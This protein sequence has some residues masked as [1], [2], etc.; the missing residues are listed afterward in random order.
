MPKW[1]GRE[2]DGKNREEG[3]K[4]EIAFS[5]ARHRSGFVWV[6]RECPVSCHARATMS[7]VVVLVHIAAEDHTANSEPAL[8][9]AANVPFKEPYSWHRSTELLPLWWW[10]T[11]NIVKCGC[12]VRACKGFFSMFFFFFS[13]NSVAL[14]QP[15]KKS[16]LI[17]RHLWRKKDDPL[18]TQQHNNRHFFFNF[19]AL[20]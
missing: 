12:L 4:R 14:H 17:S 1:T 15:E 11:C 20:K 19:L 9:A 18:P 3:R 5:P 16:V 13:Q 8:L 2:T 6:Q 7:R 10:L